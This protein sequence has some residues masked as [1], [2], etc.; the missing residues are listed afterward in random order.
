[1]NS[2]SDD[3]SLSS[4]QRSKLAMEAA[5]EILRRDEREMKLKIERVQ[6]KTRM[7]FA[8]LIDHCDGTGFARCSSMQ[9]LADLL[10]RFH[11]GVAYEGRCNCCM[12]S[13]EDTQTCR[14]IEE[15]RKSLSQQHQDYALMYLPDIDSPVEI[16]RR[17]YCY[18]CAIDEL[19]K[20]IVA[21]I[22]E[23]TTS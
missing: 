15:L 4:A 11:T 19:S 13:Y 14:Y 1:M 23:L 6:R 7:P 2:D 21:M 18:Q 8:V 3:Q 10:C 12:K 5:R 9:S 16:D 22:S 20:S 17:G